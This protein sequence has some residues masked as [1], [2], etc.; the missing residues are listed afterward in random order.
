MNTH[1]HTERLLSSFS[2]LDLFVLGS[3]L[4]KDLDS[5]LDQVGHDQLV[6]T[7]D[8]TELLLW[9]AAEILA[10]ALRKLLVVVN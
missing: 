6:S 3:E 10:G 2:D 9:L 1:S 5:L 4:L 8:V 7:H